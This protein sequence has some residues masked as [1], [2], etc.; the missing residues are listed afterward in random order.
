MEYLVGMILGDA[1]LRKPTSF[2]SVI[3]FAHA[4]RYKDYFDYKTNLLTPLGGSIFEHN[5]FDSRTGKTY[6]RYCYTSHS[7]K[8]LKWLRE[9][10]Y[11]SGKKIIPM[12]IIKRYFTNRSLSI[13][14][15]DDGSSQKYNTTIA[16][17]CY[18]KENVLEF[19][20]FIKEKFG[21]EF[22]LQTQGTI[23][24]KQRDNKNFY[25]IIFNDVMK[26]ESMQY[27][28][29][30]MSSLNSVKRGNSLEGQSRAKVV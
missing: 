16:T 9:S 28:L 24:L 18:E 8:E 29:K 13:L 1:D 15:M 17:Q 3:A 5:Y 19:I 6:P 7:I 12:T 25:D 4:S 20:Q 26:I 14:F 27:K 23:R 30:Y 21:V 2:S 10:F 11:P 22:T